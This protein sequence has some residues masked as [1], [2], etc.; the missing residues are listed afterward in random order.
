MINFELF[1]IR[2]EFWSAK[3]IGIDAPVTP[4][5]ITESVSMP[6]MMGAVVRTK[7]WT[8]KEDSAMYIKEQEESALR[9]Y[10]HLDSVGYFGCSFILQK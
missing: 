6:A 7:N 3:I 10:E 8:P 5:L 9:E 1:Y 2:R 4:V